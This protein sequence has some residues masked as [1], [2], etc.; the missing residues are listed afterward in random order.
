M[1]EPCQKVIAWKPLSDKHRK[2][3]YTAVGMV[4]GRNKRTSFLM[5]MAEKENENK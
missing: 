2:K 3:D 4:L 5:A 1:R